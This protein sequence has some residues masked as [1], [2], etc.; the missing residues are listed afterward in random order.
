MASFA[1]GD[2]VKVKNAGIAMFPMGLEG[3]VGK[4]TYISHSKTNPYDVAFE[5]LP[6]AT[7][8]HELELEKVENMGAFYIIWNPTASN[9]PTKK[10]DSEAQAIKIAEK[11]AAENPSQEFHVLKV[12]STSKLQAVTT[13]RY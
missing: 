11:L 5:G 9:P 7:A 12:V 2:T 8:F 13:Q 1:V 4:I 3:R 10:F 6:G